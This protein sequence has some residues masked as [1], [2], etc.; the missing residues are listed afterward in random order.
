MR[1]T[2]RDLINLAEKARGNAYC[3]YSEFPVGAAVECEDGTIFIGCNVENAAYGSTV[4]AE[5][6]AMTAAITAGQR[7]FR[8]IAISSEGAKYCMPC[9][10]C[11]QV[12]NELAPKIEVLSARADGRYVS[13]PISSLLPYAFEG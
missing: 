8:R 13:Y 10:N 3:P 2:D 1:A 12:L 6:V 11:R 4:C 9:G 5:V 7:Q